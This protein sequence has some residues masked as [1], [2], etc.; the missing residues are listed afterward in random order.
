[1]KVSDFL[2]FNENFPRSIL[3]CAR[4]LDSNLHKISG[5]NPGFYSNEVERVSG[6]LVSELVYGNINDAF[7]FGL[8]EYLEKLQSSFVDIGKAV[9]DTYMFHPRLD[10]ATEIAAQQQQQQ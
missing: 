3:F 7:G 1:M 8:H 10:M 6:R 9:F 5:C 2:I 4:H